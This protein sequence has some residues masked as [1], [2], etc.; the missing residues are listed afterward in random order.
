MI[1]FSIFICFK[2]RSLLSDFSCSDANVTLYMTGQDLKEAKSES[3]PG[4]TFCGATL[5]EPQMAGSYESTGSRMIVIFRAD[6]GKNAF[7]E[8]KVKF[9]AGNNDLLFSRD[10][11]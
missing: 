6:E 7:F 3:V 4:A 11:I 10:I 2:F 8:A 1:H 9:Q 5:W